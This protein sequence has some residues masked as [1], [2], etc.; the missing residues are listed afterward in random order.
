MTFI[1]FPF[2]P[3]EDSMRN[4]SSTLGIFSL[5]Y[6][7]PNF[8]SNLPWAS[9]IVLSLILQSFS[10]ICC[11][12]DIKFFQHLYS[13]LFFNWGSHFPWISGGGLRI[14]VWNSVKVWPLW[15]E[16]KDTRMKCQNNEQKKSKV[17]GKFSA[18][19]K[20]HGGCWPDYKLRAWANF[21]CKSL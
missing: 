13:G 9:L 8:Q 12:E 18:L 7:A 3:L 20:K 1:A 14:R 16:M 5:E 2:F 17:D 11:L 6:E 4:T 10:P 15:V 21:I 19:Q